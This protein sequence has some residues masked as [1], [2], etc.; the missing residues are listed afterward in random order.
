MVTLVLLAVLNGVLIGTSRAI[1]GRLAQRAGP[2]RTTLWNHVVGFSFL[3]I[4]LLAL[5][6]DDLAVTPDVPV[7]AWFGG[8]LGVLFVMLNSHVV[9]RLGASKTT[10]FV[11]AA[12]MLASIAID[13]FSSLTSQSML[14]ESAGAILIVF[15]IWLSV[16]RVESADRRTVRRETR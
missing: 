9:S 15:G 2:I 11:V 16:H 7:A 4:V 1:N 14:L 12:Q 8:V 13:G 5:F 6:S 3:S 10:S